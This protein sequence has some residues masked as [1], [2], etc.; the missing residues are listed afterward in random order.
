MEMSFPP[1][2]LVAHAQTAVAIYKQPKCIDFNINFRLCYRV[3]INNFWV[4]FGN[5]ITI[6]DTLTGNQVQG[7]IKQ[8]V[9]WGGLVTG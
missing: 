1:L 2:I 5:R 8:D 9:S 6:S 4:N 7:V 3:T